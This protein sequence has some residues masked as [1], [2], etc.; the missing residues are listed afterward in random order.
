V[1]RT[2]LFVSVRRLQEQMP[3]LSNVDLPN[4]PFSRNPTLHW[5]RVCYNNSSSSRSRD[6]SDIYTID[7]GTV[8][9]GWETINL[10]IYINEIIKYKFSVMLPILY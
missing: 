4:A 6:R 2:K 3:R 10:P 8:P 5:M 9:H 7:M 1:P